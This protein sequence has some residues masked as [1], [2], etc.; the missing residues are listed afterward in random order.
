MIIT[1]R[2]LEIGRDGRGSPLLAKR[3]ARSTRLRAFI[4]RRRPTDVLPGHFVEA[5]RSR[6]HIRDP[7]YEYDQERGP[8]HGGEIG[9]EVSGDLAN[10]C[11]ENPKNDEEADA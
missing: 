8:K 10:L 3:G 1:C 11:A 7:G 2:S 4:G 5:E 6:N 9:E